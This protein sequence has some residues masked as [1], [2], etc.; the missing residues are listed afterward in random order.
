MRTL[1]GFLLGAST[2]AFAYWLGGQHCKMQSVSNTEAFRLRSECA[3]A[4]QHL[5]EAHKPAWMVNSVVSRYD[6]STNRCYAYMSGIFSDTPPLIS[7]NSVMD[8]LFDAQTGEML[9]SVI[10]APGGDIAY[11][12]G[13]P[14]NPSSSAARAV[15][16]RTMADERKQ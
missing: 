2:I 10:H 9:A 11:I 15:I 13:G 1:V 8:I 6:P 4:A 12:K 5:T 14:T 7:W 3:Q 16:D